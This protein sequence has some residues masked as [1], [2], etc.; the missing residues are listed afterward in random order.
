M[1]YCGLFGSATRAVTEYPLSTMAAVLVA[2]ATVACDSG[3]ATTP[4]TVSLVSVA[5]V[6]AP[7]SMASQ[8]LL[9]DQDL[10]CLPASFEMQVRCVDRNGD[11]V[12]AFGREGE[13][14]GEFK[15][16]PRLLRGP[17]GTVGAISLNRL[18]IF[19]RGGDLVDHITLPITF[20]RPAAKAFDATL[21]AHSYEGAK[22]FPIEIDLSSG[23]L[24]WER[25]DIPD[26]VQ[27]ECGSVGGGVVSP[28]GSWAHTACQR[29]LVFLD[30]RDAST[31]TVIQAPTYAEEL[32][33]E[34]DIADFENQA[35]SVAFRM[36]VDAFRETPKRNHLMAGRS[37]AYDAQGRLWVATQRDRAQ[38]SYL[39]IYVGTEYVVSV[40]VKDRLLGYDLYGSTLAV[41]VERAPDAAGIGWRALDWYDIAEV[42]LGLGRP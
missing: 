10:V 30:D 7:F 27:T 23:A 22:I 17:N 3:T 11:L 4:T 31:A 1:T 12:G 13:G 8:P 26:V 38:F 37:L 36:D 5:S 34:R 35:R 41:L 42:D 16:P 9:V 20:P 25:H 28:T 15:L 14:P 29:E 18:T 40:Q 19:T 6:P 33:N 24:L 32:P 39:D 2:A 21:L